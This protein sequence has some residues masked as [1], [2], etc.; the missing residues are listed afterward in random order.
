MT[1]RRSRPDSA[2]SPLLAAGSVP[3]ALSADDARLQRVV[4]ALL[5][6]AKR[7]PELQLRE[8]LQAAGATEQD[9]ATLGTR[10]RAFLPE[11]LLHQAR[12]IARE[13][14]LGHPAPRPLLNDAQ[15]RRALQAARTP[16]ADALEPTPP[17]ARGLRRRT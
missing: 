17:V 12:T 4:M 6:Y 7:P 15:A 2:A 8:A 1:Q 10:L 5:A 14:A 13:I 11:P 16:L 3:P 9:V